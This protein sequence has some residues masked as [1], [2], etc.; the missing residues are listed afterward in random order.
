MARNPNIRAVAADEKPPAKSRKP[1]TIKAAVDMSERELL[2]AL[3]A[4]AAAEIDSGPPAHTLPRLMQQLRDLDK[5]IRAIDAREDEHEEPTSGN[6]ASGSQAFD[7]ASA[8]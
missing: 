5:E 7:P 6:R 4:K 2:V 8:I 3:R 1:V